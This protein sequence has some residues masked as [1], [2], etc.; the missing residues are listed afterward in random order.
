MK[1]A[2]PLPPFTNIYGKFSSVYRRGFLNPP[3]SFAYLAAS[4]EK[5]GH[6]AIIIDGEAE[7]LGLNTILKRVAEFAPDAIG[8]SATSPTFDLTLDFAKEIKA[9]FP[10]VPLIIGGIHIAI[11]QKSVLEENSVFDFGVIGDGEVALPE[12]LD[13]LKEPSAYKEIKGL[14]WRS[15][16][17]VVQNDFRL[18]EKNLDVY[19]FPARHL[20]RNEL[21]LRNTPYHG[22]RTTAAFMSS[23]GCPYNCIYCAVKNIP[24]GTMVRFRSPENIVEELEQIVHGLGITH[25]QFNDDCLTFRHDQV[26]ALCESIQKRGLKFTWEGLSRGD[27]VDKEILTELKR[28]GL[29]RLSFGIESGNASILK[30]LQKEETLEDIANGIRLAHEAGIITRGSVI[31]GS[32]Y[33]TRREIEDTFHFITSLKELDETVINI[34]QPY[35]GTKV[36]EMF[37]NGEGGT[38]ILTSGLSGLRRFGNA[39]VEVNDLS[40]D[41]LVRLQRQGM[42]RFYFHPQK[43]IRTITIN[44]PVALLQTAIGAAWSI[45]R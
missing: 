15:G 39:C 1:V 19:P 13:R 24:N 10:S 45:F 4:L 33:E 2:L 32:P 18:P 6:T 35:P 9:A 7:Y 5:H 14:V 41:T 12:L 44:H 8:L 29:V 21:Y 20:L 25:V 42:R 40:A 23:R 36:R 22:Y 30:V 11:Y 34:M 38:R 27:K 28:A 26:L 16:E 31:I 37:L 43:I 17:A 3:L